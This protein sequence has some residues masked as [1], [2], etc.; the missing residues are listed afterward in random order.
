MEEKLNYINF[1]YLVETEHN[2]LKETLRDRH[3]WL[4]K[5]PNLLNSL[6]ECSYFTRSRPDDYGIFANALYDNS[7]YSFQAIE[8]LTIRGYYLESSTLIRTLFEVFAKLRY[9]KKY[10]DLCLD[11]STKKVKIQFKTMFEEFSP[12]LYDILYKQLLSEFAH[13]GFGANIFHSK[14]IKPNFQQPILGC[15]YSEQFSN[16]TINTMTQLFYCFLNIIPYIFDEYREKVKEDVERRRIENINWLEDRFNDQMVNHPKVKE[17]YE[18]LFPLI[19]V[20]K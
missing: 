8:I 5:F 16:L 13:G 2:V 10:P 19:R 14:L 12:G 6:F 17:F 20:E 1:D 15:Y 7:I 9:F 3:Y 11:Y 4:D 18:L